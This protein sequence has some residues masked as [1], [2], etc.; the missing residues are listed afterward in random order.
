MAEQSY[1]TKTKTVLA[2][3]NALYYRKKG[4][5]YLK[6]A[7]LSSFFTENKVPKT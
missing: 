1:C 4:I 2:Q 6:G 7:I 5:F 3:K